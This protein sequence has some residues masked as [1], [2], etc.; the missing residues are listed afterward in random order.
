MPPAPFPTGWPRC[1]RP[2]AH[3]CRP[4]VDR[5]P[6]GRALASLEIGRG[7]R[8]VLWSATDL[9]AVPA[10]RRP[11]QAGRHLRAGQRTA[12]A[13]GSRPTSS[14][15]AIPTLV[16]TDPTGPCRRACPAARPSAE[17]GDR[18][19]ADGHAPFCDHRV[20]RAD[21]HVAFFTSGSTGRPEGSRPLPR[22]PTT[23]APIPGRSSSHGAPWSAPTRSST[24]E[25]GPSPSS[26]GRPATRSSSSSPRAPRRSVDAVARHRAT[27]LNCVPA[28]WRR[29]IDHVGGLGRRPLCLRSGSPTPGRRRHPLDL[30][31]A[32][33]GM[34]PQ[35]HL[36]VFYGSTEAGQRRLPR[37]CRHPD[38]SRG[39][40]DRRPRGQGADRRRRRAVGARARCSSTATS[41]TPTPRPPAWS[42]AG[43]APAT[44]PRRTKTGSS[45]SW[46]AP[47]T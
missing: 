37:P 18:A 10:V 12:G 23:S 13:R 9:D 47:G 33:E 30:L 20:V 43:T 35:A 6:V 27:R 3:L 38:A 16:V 2:V 5:Q 11:E 15:A 45:A 21:P 46:A 14:P 36:R 32:I 29:I 24:W 19:A 41:T 31:V 40:A 44:W 1:W 8:V 25:R 17:L 26:S 4:R 42:T 34:L 39:A 7:S 28:V 22:R